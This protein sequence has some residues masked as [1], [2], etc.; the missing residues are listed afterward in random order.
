MKR[1]IM[2]LAPLPFFF[3]ATSM[4]SGC[5]LAQHQPIHTTPHRIYEGMTIYNKSN[6]TLSEE[7][8][9][10]RFRLFQESMQ[11]LEGCIPMSEASMRSSLRAMA[12][13][14]LPRGSVMILGKE[15]SAFTDLTMYIFVPY[16]HFGVSLLR[17]E[18]I[19]GYLYRTGAYPLG[20]IFHTSPFFEKCG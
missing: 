2:R 9:G 4:L 3:L 7:E 11:V 8:W 15:A 17:H 18:F 10:E 19:H 6:E 12:I 5:A 14:I 1:K 13:V 20:D 16:N